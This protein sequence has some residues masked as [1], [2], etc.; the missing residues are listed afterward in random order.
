MLQSVRK[1]ELMRLQVSGRIVSA[2][3]LISHTVDGGILP[4]C[5]IFRQTIISLAMKSMLEGN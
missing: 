4:D 5:E 3:E 1:D 2:G